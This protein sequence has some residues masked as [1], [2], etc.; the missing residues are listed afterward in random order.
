MPVRTQSGKYVIFTD[1]EEGNPLSIISI[2][3]GFLRQIYE[4]EAQEKI[5]DYLEKAMSGS[6]ENLKKVSLEV[7]PGLITFAN[8][9]EYKVAAIKKETDSE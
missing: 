3:K 4:E 2:V 9:S 7:V 1:Q 6:Y 8:S 5:D